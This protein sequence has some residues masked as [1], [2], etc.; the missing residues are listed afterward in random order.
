M[1]IL[2]CVYCIIEV[3]MFLFN[4]NFQICL[5]ITGMGWI[6]IRIRILIR[7]SKNS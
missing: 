1:W 7:N 3:K 6:R 2:D 5:N 4:I